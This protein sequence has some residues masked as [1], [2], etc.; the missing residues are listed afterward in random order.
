M[1]FTVRRKDD[2]K[3][4]G[5][6][7]FGIG[8]FICFIFLSADN[9]FGLNTVG[10]SKAGTPGPAQSQDEDT[11]STSTIPS[12]SSSSRVNLAGHDLLASRTGPL[13]GELME[14]D[15][16]SGTV[17]FRCEVTKASRSAVKYAETPQGAAVSEVS[18]MLFVGIGLLA[19]SFSRTRKTN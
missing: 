15:V 17:I 4:K 10:N 6:L 11:T 5:I 19:L 2:L 14:E 1:I 16:D 9:V 7:W 12:L 3:G 13:H 8:V 18:T